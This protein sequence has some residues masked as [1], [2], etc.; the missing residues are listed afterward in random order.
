MGEQTWRLTRVVRKARKL[1]RLKIK[2]EIV[3]KG[4]GTP[5]ALGKPQGHPRHMERGIWKGD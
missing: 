5:G 3:D 1:T 4:A 2:R